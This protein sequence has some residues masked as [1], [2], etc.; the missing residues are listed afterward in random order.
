MCRGDEQR[1]VMSTTQPA[2]DEMQAGKKNMSYAFL[3][4]LR[5]S[6]EKTYERRR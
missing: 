2:I 5:E 6:E 1:G 3:K 4:V